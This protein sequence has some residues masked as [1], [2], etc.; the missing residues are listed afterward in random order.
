MSFS[1]IYDSSIDQMMMRDHFM[2]ALIDM[3]DHDTRVVA[4][5]ADMN[6]TL[7]NY[8]KLWMLREKYKDRFFDTGIQEANLVGM[9]AGLSL[10]GKL[11]FIHAFS[12]FITRR[13]YDQIYLSLAYAG[14]SARLIGSDPG[15]TAGYNGG[16]HTSL[17]DVGIMRCIPN[18][19]IFDVTDGVMLESVMRDMCDIKRVMYIR[20][21]RKLKMTK[22]YGEGS[23]FEIGKA[24]LLREGADV[25]LVASGIMVAKALTAADM[26]ELEGIS[27]QV[28][29]V[30][31]IKPLDEQCI[32]DCAR[33]THAMVS[34]ENHR[35]VNGQASAIADVLV[36]SGI[37]TAY[38]SVGIGERFGEVGPADYLEKAYALT[39]DDICAKARE[40]VEKKRNEKRYLYE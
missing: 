21:P 11:P 12:Q 32:C 4:G 25:T 7:C 22:V 37:P 5:D 39:V 9:A 6:I 1:V 33:K 15:Y 17:E 24:N 16:T 19:V 27:A 23:K 20:T 30:V 28:I 26:L 18:V 13:A 35:V 8:D 2:N 34:C 38:A 40:V 29:D 31:T 14:L 3:M 10:G 36:R